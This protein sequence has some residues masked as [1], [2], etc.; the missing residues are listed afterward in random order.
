MT[1]VSCGLSSLREA[2]IL[3]SLPHAHILVATTVVHLR[4]LIVKGDV[5]H[6]SFAEFRGNV[7]RYRRRHH[8]RTISENVEVRR[9][10]T[11]MEKCKPGALTNV[12]VF[13]EP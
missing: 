1:G 12:T 6:C 4:A 11:P 2:S 3:P 9:A 5:C 8:Y 10:A 13:R 7:G